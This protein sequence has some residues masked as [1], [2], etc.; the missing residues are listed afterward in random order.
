VIVACKGASSVWEE[1]KRVG[2]SPL[3]ADTFAA[4]DHTWEWK[5]D[6]EGGG[7]SCSTTVTAQVPLVCRVGFPMEAT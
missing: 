3:L 6:E 2:E 5:K 1:E 4:P 7:T